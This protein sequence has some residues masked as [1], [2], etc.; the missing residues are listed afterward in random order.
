MALMA[1]KW[2][3]LFK[4]FDQNHDGIITKDDFE[5]NK[6]NFIKVYKLQGVEADN[7]KA[8][9][10]KFWH[11]VVLHTHKSQPIIKEGRFVAR[12]KKAYKTHRSA[13]VK[14]MHECNDHLLHVIDRDHDGFLSFD[15]LFEDFRAWNQ[16]IENLVRGM[17]NLMG[18]NDDNLVPNENFNKLYTEFPFGKNK[19]LFH[20][21]KQVYAESGFPV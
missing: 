18:P 14:R 13:A 15:E 12:Y 8:T 10:D 7:V 2:R 21:V 20:D 11:C 5:V 4:I 16:G 9:L 17:F 3:T 1:E 6:N 19:E